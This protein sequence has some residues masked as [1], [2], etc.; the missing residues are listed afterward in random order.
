M[1]PVIIPLVGHIDSNNASAVEQDILAQLGGSAH[2]PVVLDASKLDYISSAGLRVLLRLRKTHPDITVTEVSS[3]IYEIFEMT[4]FTEILNVEKAYQRISVEGCEVIGEGANGKV[5]RIGPDSVVKTYKNADALSEIQHEREVAR[6]ALILGVPTAISYDVVRVGE[7]YGAVFELLNATSFSKILADE[8]ERM[9][10]CVEEYIKLLRQIHSTTV[11]EGK[12]PRAIDR[13]KEWV[14]GVRP[15]L[16]DELVKKLTD[17]VRALPERNTMLHGD[18]HTKNIVLADGE[19]LLI[20]MDTLSTG[21]PIIEFVQMYNSYIG[22]GE[23]DPEVI[24]RFQ[25]YSAETARTFWNRTLRAYFG[26]DEEKVLDTERKIRCLSYV[27]LIDWSLRRRNP[28]TDADRAARELWTSE[29]IELLSS[30]DSL[31]FALDAAE[32]K[33][34]SEFETGADAGNL[35]EV[36][37]F[38][39]RYLAAVRCPMK[40]RMQI[41]VAV[42]EIFTNIASY[43]Y[44]TDGGKATVR[45]ELTDDPI[46]VA[47]TFIDNGVPYDP[48]GRDD[49]DITL[50]AEQRKSSGLGVFMAKQTM[51]DVAYAYRDGQNILT[52][53]KTI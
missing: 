17:M 43:A 27:R 46:T 24:A 52:L 47:I 22:F 31:D 33:A 40:A 2:A 39:E 30:L 51:D 3:E 10:W 13:V 8:P 18:Y 38:V 7:S 19:V 25:G 14:K 44:E 6:T 32:E 50:P 26:A 49:P 34:L 5:Y 23:N 21:H 9:D 20:D 45:V 15:V 42:E 28:G 1:E 29:L 37:S 41:E 4:G 36:Q 35:P 12:L 11:P 16:S 53:K 48:L